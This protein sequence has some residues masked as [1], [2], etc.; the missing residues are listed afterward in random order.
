[1]AAIS[2][3][4]KRNAVFCNGRAYSDRQYRVGWSFSRLQHGV[5]ASPLSPHAP[6]AMAEI[7]ATRQRV[8]GMRAFCNSLFWQPSQGGSSHSCCSRTPA[9]APHT[10]EG[11]NVIRSGRRMR[12]TA[13]EFPCSP[14]AYMLSLSC[15]G[16]TAGFPR[17]GGILGLIPAKTIGRSTCDEH[18]WRYGSG[19]SFSRD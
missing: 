13:M 17:A 15:L 5:G 2:T 11:S 18:R 19:T 10:S 1:M 16:G 12:P 8:L 3:S 6:T 7:K 9:S 4:H 14:P